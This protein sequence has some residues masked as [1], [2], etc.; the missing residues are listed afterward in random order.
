MLNISIGFSASLDSVCVT[1][2]YMSIVQRSLYTLAQVCSCGTRTG[3]KGV[4]QDHVWGRMIEV[5]RRGG[6]AGR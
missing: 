3:R 2:Q 4:N 1:F 5:S 6:T